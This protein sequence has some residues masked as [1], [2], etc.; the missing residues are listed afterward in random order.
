MIRRRHRT[1]DWGGGD[2]LPDKSQRNHLRVGN[3]GGRTRPTQPPPA[4]ASSVTNHDG[5]IRW[6]WV[7]TVADLWA[8]WLARR[9]EG[10]WPVRI[11]W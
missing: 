4:G 8:A 5:G 7:A 9:G 11:G 10:Q 6:W 3:G 1:G 2:A